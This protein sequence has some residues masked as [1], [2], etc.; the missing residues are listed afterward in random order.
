MKTPTNEQIIQIVAQF[1]GFNDIT[2]M[3][4]HDIVKET[5]IKWENIRSEK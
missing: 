2:M 3:P 4:F 1:R 5:I